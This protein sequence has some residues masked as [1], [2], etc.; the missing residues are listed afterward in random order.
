[1]S[2][3]AQ[4]RLANLPCLYA[5]RLLACPLPPAPLSH[6]LDASLPPNGGCSAIAFLEGFSAATPTHSGNLADCWQQ[7]AVVKSGPTLQFY[8]NNQSAGEA[9]GISCGCAL[10]WA[11]CRAARIA[12]L[13]ASLA[14]G[15]F[16]AEGPPAFPVPQGSLQCTAPTGVPLSAAP[17]CLQDPPAPAML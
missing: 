14:G 13:P 9:K 12:G 5:V 6:W 4:L 11:A 15:L 16:L 7:L 17:Q 1:M 10:G 8:Y 3:P 2:L